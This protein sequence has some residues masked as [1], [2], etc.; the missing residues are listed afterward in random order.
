MKR[1]MQKLLGAMQAWYRIDRVRIAPSD[2]RLLQ[3]DVGDRFVLLDDVFVVQQRLLKSSEAACEVDLLLKG[4][5]VTATL[6]VQR[7]HL[8]EPVHAR[9]SREGGSQ[10]VF[11]SDVLPLPAD[12][13]NGRPVDPVPREPS[14]CEGLSS[15]DRAQADA[16]FPRVDS[17]LPAFRVS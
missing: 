14:R 17:P 13:S 4:D 15:G 6:H 7:R 3:L 10:T 16:A 12:I 8:T 11:D 1:V 9:L 5:H 2:G